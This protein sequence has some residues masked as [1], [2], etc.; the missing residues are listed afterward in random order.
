[1]D[2]N[3]VNNKMLPTASN[4]AIRNNFFITVRVLG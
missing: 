1:V 3:P 4:V 2:L